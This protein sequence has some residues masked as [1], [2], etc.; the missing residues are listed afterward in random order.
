MTVALRFLPPP[1]KLYGLGAYAL[2]ATFGPNM[3]ASLAAFWTDQVSWMFVF[4]QVVPGM[5][6]ALV[7]TGWGLPPGSVAH[8]TFSADRS[9]RDAHRL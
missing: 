3:A 8:R 9:V 1:F 7:L 4:W 5:L 2:T 6:I